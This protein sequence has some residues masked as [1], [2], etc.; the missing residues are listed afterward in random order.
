VGQADAEADN[1]DVSDRD[2]ATQRVAEA[3]PLEERRTPTLSYRSGS[4]SAN[5]A[6]GVGAAPTVTDDKGRQ[7]EKREDGSTVRRVA[8]G[9]TYKAD[10]KVGRNDPCPCG[11]GQKFKRCH[12]A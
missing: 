4:G 12:G 9:S 11:S 10:E 6:A 2:D 7:V 5:Y 8:A 3:I 1:G